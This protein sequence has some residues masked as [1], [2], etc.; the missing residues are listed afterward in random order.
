LQL[1]VILLAFNNTL[2]HALEDKYTQSTA[3]HCKTSLYKCNYLLTV[4]LHACNCPV[5]AMQELCHH[6]HLCLYIWISV[7][8]RWCAVD[9]Q[10]SGRPQQSSWIQWKMQNKAITQFKVIEVSIN[11]KPVCDFLLVI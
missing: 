7:D 3:T 10:F 2:P 6:W 1:T 8:V 11:R 5:F 4:I 9:V